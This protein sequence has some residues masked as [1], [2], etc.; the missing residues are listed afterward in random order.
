MAYELLNHGPVIPHRLHALVRLVARRPQ[1]V[2]ARLIDLLQPPSMLQGSSLPHGARPI[3]VC[4]GRVS[5]VSI[6]NGA[7]E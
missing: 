3:A 7:T 2:K 5:Q 6:L 1:I 4:I